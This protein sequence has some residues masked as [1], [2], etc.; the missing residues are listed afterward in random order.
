MQEVS[1]SMS[2]VPMLP[3]VFQGVASVLSCC[4]RQYDK[5]VSGR[6]YHSFRQQQGEVSTIVDISNLAC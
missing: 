6:V 1:G 2:S 4:L 5:A 3:A